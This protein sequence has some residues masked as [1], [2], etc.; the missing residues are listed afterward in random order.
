MSHRN[1][2]WETQVLQ[3]K[4][5]QGWDQDLPPLL[6]STKIT[7]STAMGKR[8]RPLFYQPQDPEEL[9]DIEPQSPEVETI[10][11]SPHSPHTC[12]PPGEQDTQ[13]HPGKP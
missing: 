2:P 10:T 12:D 11:P 1:L 6:N 8:A 13:V 3:R 5:L 9:K 4:A 7:V